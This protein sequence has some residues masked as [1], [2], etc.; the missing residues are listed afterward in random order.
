MRRHGNSARRFLRTNGLPQM[1][2]HRLRL[3]LVYPIE[4]VAAHL[5]VRNQSRLAKYTQMMGNRRLGEPEH[6]R[7]LRDVVAVLAVFR[8][9]QVVKDS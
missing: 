5:F 1:V 6:R 8:M 4:Y 7:E 3:F 9:R 2:E